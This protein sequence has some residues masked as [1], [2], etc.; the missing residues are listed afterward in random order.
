MLVE[1][2]DEVGDA[3]YQFLPT[4]HRCDKYAEQRYR[5][6]ASGRGEWRGDKAQ[7]WGSALI[8]WHGRAA[9]VA[10]RINQM[11]RLSALYTWSGRKQLLRLDEKHIRQRKP[12][13]RPEPNSLLV[14]VIAQAEDE[15]LGGPWC[16]TGASRKVSAASCTRLACIGIPG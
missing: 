5:A 15:G 14:A 4:E 10:T 7:W 2:A 1:D 12:H 16:L 13:W 3:F 6:G 11:Y 8:T 9:H